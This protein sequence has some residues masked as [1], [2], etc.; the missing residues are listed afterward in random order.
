MTQTFR[1]GQDLTV[2]AEA[3]EAAGIKDGDVVVIKQTASG[4]LVHVADPSAAQRTDEAIADGEGRVFESDEEF[5]SYLRSF[6]EPE[7]D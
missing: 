2:P 6:P 1:K 5:D 4:L 7:A 3:A